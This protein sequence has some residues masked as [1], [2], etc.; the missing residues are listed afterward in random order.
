MFERVVEVERK[1]DLPRDGKKLNM[2]L[3]DVLRAQQRVIIES[4]C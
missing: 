3:I 4:K 2:I 1:K